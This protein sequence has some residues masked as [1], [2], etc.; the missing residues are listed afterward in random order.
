MRAPASLLLA[1][2]MLAAASAAPAAWVV[3]EHGAC[4]ERWTAGDLARGP[5]AMLNGVL[6]PFRTTA[7]GAVYAWTQDSW[8]PWQ[9]VG[10][11]PGTM[12]I[13]AGAGVIEGVWWIGTGLVDTLSGGALG[14]APEK[15]TELSLAPEVS[16]II[17]DADRPAPTPDP[18]GR[19]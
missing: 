10:L 12:I 19:P 3:D 13:S 17:A 4:V 15:A 1:V 9:I 18:W 11:G 7:G 16:P 5:T 8:W 6:L 2:V 14:A